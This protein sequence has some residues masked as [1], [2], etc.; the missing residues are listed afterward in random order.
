MLHKFLKNMP[1]KKRLTLLILLAVFIVMTVGGLIMINLAIDDRNSAMSDQM[2]LMSTLAEESL[3]EPLWTYNGSSLKSAGDALFKN[4]EIV[5]VTVTD[6]NGAIL[7][8]RDIE[9]PLFEGSRMTAIERPI[10]KHDLL[11]GKVL[12]G[13]T[14]YY[15]ELALRSEVM[16]HLS[17]ILI[18]CL[19]IWLLVGY[20][21]SMV[22]R[23]IA[24]LCQGTDEIASGHFEKRL[25]FDTADEIGRL[26]DKFN[27]MTDNVQHMLLERQEK[28]AELRRLTASLRQREERFRAVVKNTEIIIYSVDKNG[29]FTLSEGLGL[30]ML[31]LEPGEVV[32]RSAFDLYRDYPDI[33]QA[34]AKSLAGETVFGEHHVGD[35][36]FDNRLVPVFNENGDQTGIVGTAIDITERVRTEKRL[37]KSHQDLTATHEELLATEEELRTKYDEISTANAKI[38]RQ[39]AV[40]STLNEAALGLMARLDT[41]EA[42][43]AVVARLAELAGTEHVYVFLFDE[44]KHSAVRVVGQGIYSQDIGSTRNVDEGHIGEVRRLKK[45]VIIEDYSTW[46]KLIKS[47]IHK[48]IHAS[49]QVPLFAAGEIFGT[50]GM[51]YTNSD[52]RFSDSDVA[53]IE[54]FAILVAITLENA[55]KVRELKESKETVEE[56][57][58]AVKDVIM[59]NDGDTGEIV[60]INRQAGT[61]FG[62]PIEE[63]RQQGVALIASPQNADDALLRIRKTITEGPQL[64]ERQTFARDGKRL[65]LEVQTSRAVIDGKVRCVAVI[66]DITQR[67]QMEE[68]IIQLEAQ[69]RAILEAIPDVIVRYNRQGDFL[70]YK[71]SKSKAFTDLTSPVGKNVRDFSPPHFLPKVL[72]AI[73]QALR[74]G[75]Y[76]YETKIFTRGEEAYIEERYVKV[77]N[78]EV[79]VLV[80]DITERHRMEEQ[81]K[82]LQLMDPMTGIYNRSFFETGMEKIKIGENCDIGMFICDVDGLKFIN[83]TLGHSF[84]DELLKR[85]AG[86]LS[87]GIRLPNYAARVGGDEFA[88]ILFSPTKAQME[89]LDRQYQEKVEAYNRECP[90]LPLSLSFGW[91][92]DNN[93]KIDL[94]FKTADNSMYRRKMHQHQ[95]IRG[96]IVKIMMKALEAKDHVTEGHVDRLGDMM[97]KMGQK[98]GLS[99]GDMA[100][101]R[102]F[103]KF[104]DIGKVGIPDNILNKPGRLTDDEMTIM[105]QHCDIGFRIARASSDLEPIADWILKHQEFWDGGG[106]PLKLSGEQIPIQC[107][108]LAIVDAFDAMVNDRPYRKAMT[109]D[110]ALEEIRRCAGT[111]FDPKLAGLFIEMVTSEQA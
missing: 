29:V 5:S 88:V 27:I 49:V 61:L 24:E 70:S 82:F 18:T 67:K 69:N 6:V 62:Y 102:L 58:N 103:A 107:R 48:Q 40:L 78:D 57:F 16:N 73:D 23:P 77:N 4:R 90:D 3:V 104:H 72:T 74:Q 55:R 106:Y 42:L 79:L 93:Q 64:Y 9:S 111:Q 110:K 33:T 45:S 80:R 50:L 105:R 13:F 1:I 109:W 101:L 83:D 19:I 108:I 85:A 12:V 89:L 65:V 98:L 96:S 52:L 20:I 68:S 22:T 60:A 63:I 86:L 59:V 36:H 28:I 84:G 97:E 92:I 2:S 37:L 35:V 38:S 10:Y 8:N 39:N 43:T 71:A 17:S 32:G 66:R 26:A 21:S 15:S 75:E 31:G 41:A 56:I 81:V 11:L 76:A 47:N 87:D 53:L 94:I 14:D 51:A 25:T 7:Y 91:A 95:S 100:D 34:L 54:Q 99:Q 46:D 30:K 44:E